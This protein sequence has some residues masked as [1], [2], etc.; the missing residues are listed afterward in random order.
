MRAMSKGVKP[1]R[2]LV[3]EGE[4]K[5]MSKGQN[6]AKNELGILRSDAIE[7]KLKPNRRALASV[8]DDHQA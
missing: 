5:K 3:E 6:L 1:P 7:E 4:K 8:W 2:V